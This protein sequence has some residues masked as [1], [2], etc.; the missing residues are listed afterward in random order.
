MGLEA[1]GVR[2]VAS[3]ER[4]PAKLSRPPSIGIVCVDLRGSLVSKGL[5]C[6][7][8]LPATNRKVVHGE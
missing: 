1:T 3:V 6:T 8:Q 5:D 2:K 7:T 4:L